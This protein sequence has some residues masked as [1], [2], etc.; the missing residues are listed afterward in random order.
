[1]TGYESGGHYNCWTIK[2]EKCNGKFITFVCTKS[3]K[4]YITH[5][6]CTKHE[7]CVNY[8]PDGKC[9]FDTMFVSIPKRWK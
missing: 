6:E 9:K 1:M 8:S 4:E 3:G 5:G 2:G 7:E